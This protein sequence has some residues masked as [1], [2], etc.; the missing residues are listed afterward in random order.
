MLRHNG[1]R[2]LALVVSIAMVSFFGRPANAQSRIAESIQ[3]TQRVAVKGS[4][5][6]HLIAMSR[7]NGRL[8]G[9]QKLGR[10]VL[11][12]TPTEAQDKAAADLIAA[13]HDASSPLF[14]KWLTPAEFGQQFGVTSTHPKC[15]SG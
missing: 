4:S 15:V 10:M 7:D 14:H 3:S 2:N 12:L 13:Q 9:D 1:C 6:N 5:P 11:L 8:S